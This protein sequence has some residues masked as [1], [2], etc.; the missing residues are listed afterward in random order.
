MSYQSI[1][2]TETIKV[3]KLYSIHYFE[4]MNNFFLKGE[5]HNFWEFLCVDK[6]EIEVT[7]N[8]R[9]SVLQKGEIIF[10]KPNEFHSAKSNGTS[11]SNLVM[12][13]FECRSPSMKFFNDQRFHVTERERQLMTSILSESRKTF[14]NPLNEP[15][16]AKMQFNPDAPNGSRQMIKITLEMMLL[17]MLRRIQTHRLLCPVITSSRRSN[18]EIL[19]R[20]IIECLESHIQEKLTIDQICH[21]TLMGRSQLQKLFHRKNNCGIIDYF[22]RMKIDAAKQ[23]IRD[24]HLNFTQISNHLGY[25]SIHYFSRQF[26]KTTGMTPSEYSSSVKLLNVKPHATSMLTQPV[27]VTK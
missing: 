6:G 8:D 25:T 15:Y 14:S 19:Y 5:R 26:K 12:V 16:P 17:Q 3:E 24:N 22:S 20:R 4:Y 2:L 1:T 11:L 18:D 10:Y 9:S 23:L 21:E 27:S 13:S 7:S